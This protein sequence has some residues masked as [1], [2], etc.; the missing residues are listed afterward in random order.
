M[1]VTPNDGFIYFQPN[2]AVDEAGQVA[3]SAFALPNGHLD[4]VLLVSG[5][6]ENSASSHRC[7]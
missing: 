3:I 4:E 1:T 7:G 2:L 6:L 5:P